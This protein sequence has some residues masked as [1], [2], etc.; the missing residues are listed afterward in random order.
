MDPQSNSK[1]DQELF[2]EFLQ[3]P[4]LSFY[5]SIRQPDGQRKRAREAFFR[6]G[7]PPQF[8]YP[9]AETAEIPTYLESLHAFEERVPHLTTDQTIA[10]LYVAKIE[11]L[12]MRALLIQAVQQKDAERVSE[13]SKELFGPIIP[14][15]PELEQELD[16]MLMKESTFYKHKKNVNA[17]LF[18]SMVRRVLDAYGIHEWDVE[19]HNGTSVKISHG[20]HLRRVRVPKSLRITRA[21]AAR[22][23]THEIEVHVLRTHNGAHSP[24]HLFHRGLDRY[25][26]IDEGLAI[27]Y[28]LQVP[29]NQPSFLPGFWDAYA[30]LLM[31]DG[32]FTD[33]FEQIRHARLQL[34]MHVGD[35]H[36][37]ETARDAA[38]RLC[39]RAYRGICDT[40]EGGVGFFRDHIYRS[41]YLRVKEA[42][43]DFTPDILPYLFVGN[44]GIHH[45]PMLSELGGPY[46][47]TP[48]MIS[49]QIMK[50]VMQNAK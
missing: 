35:E 27:Y 17:E 14:T 15:R 6:T 21:R 30:T 22:L 38:W 5:W 46:G 31:A 33:T 47:Q 34:A 7:T 18:M 29:K 8:T 25:L 40:S 16:K 32:N 43:D 24:L 12:R 26:P 48:R 37:E 11:E 23:L 28:Q 45:L 36:P 4:P 49:K 50:E 39:T 10:R 9:N 19:L 13:I 3:L 44:I 20:E 41:G 2:E 1:L 42:I